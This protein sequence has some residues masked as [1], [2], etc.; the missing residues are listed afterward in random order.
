[1]WRQHL[2]TRSEPSARRT[3]NLLRLL[4]GTETSLWSPNKAA[5]LQCVIVAS[6]QPLS[7]SLG[8]SFPPS[9][10]S[11]C[12]TQVLEA[13]L[14]TWYTVLGRE[15]VGSNT[16]GGACLPD[17]LEA[18]L[19]RHLFIMLVLQ[20]RDSCSALATTTWQSSHE[21]LFA[22]MSALAVS[23]LAQNVGAT[24]P[25]HLCVGWA[26]ANDLPLG[27]TLL[28]LATISYSLAAGA[29]S[30]LSGSLVISGFTRYLP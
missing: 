10:T 13:F 20:R 27:S 16:G 2:R 14:L 15:G 24:P 8:T 11:S 28:I 6:R 29:S 26:L 30:P 1:M 23:R 17:P 19:S 25:D 12:H 7:F 3:Q 22:R 5:W 4:R 9:T 21:V 18:L